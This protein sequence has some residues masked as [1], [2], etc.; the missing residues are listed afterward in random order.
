MFAHREASFYEA[1]FRLSLIRLA[2]EQRFE[3]GALYRTSAFRALDLSEKGAISYF[4]GMVICKLFADQMLQTPWLLHLDVFKDQL[5]L[6]IV[7][8]RSRP[9]LVGQSKSGVWHVFECKGRSSVPGSEE[10]RKAKEQAQR[11]TRVDST[12]CK[13]HVGAIAYFR[14][15]RLEFHWRDPEPKESKELVPFNVKLSKDAWRQYYAP[16]MALGASTG[17]DRTS[18]RGAAADVDVEIH[19]E[20]R[21]RLVM[22]EWEEAR[23]MAHE[24]RRTLV[25]EGFHPDGLR[26]RAGNTWHEKLGQASTS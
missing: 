15:E 26:V 10:R 14:Q 13:L 1:L 16:A 19:E 24:M 9:D 20:I 3:S 4:L 23:T 2:V 22:G 6:A 21:E 11:L 8:G 17:V 5:D 18:D 7:R 12:D 25:E